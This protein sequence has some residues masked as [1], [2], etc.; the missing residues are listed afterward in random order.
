[1]KKNIALVYQLP[2]L[3]AYDAIEYSGNLIVTGED[4]VFQY[5]INDQTG[6]LQHLSTIPVS[7]TPDW[8]LT[9]N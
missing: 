7:R 6:S 1:M 2:A 5:Q 8:S 3:H 9:S 4:G